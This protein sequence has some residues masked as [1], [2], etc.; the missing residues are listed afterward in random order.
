[1]STTSM[2]FI[3][4]KR[5]DI[6][7]AISFDKSQLPVKLSDWVFD[8]TRSK[9]KPTTIENNYLGVYCHWDGDPTGVGD[10]LLKLYNG[11]ESIVNLIAG[12]DCSCID[13]Q[14]V[15]HYANR[16]GEKWKFIKPRQ[17]KKIGDM[18]GWTCYTYIFKDG[19]WRVREGVKGK[20]VDLQEYLKT[21]YAYL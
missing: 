11:Y 4:V 16:K 13:R 18:G 12:G 6:G 19:K 9:C 3:K 14:K 15:R 17:I 5:E 21:K 7:K 2:I 1:M 10:T 8:K 20:F